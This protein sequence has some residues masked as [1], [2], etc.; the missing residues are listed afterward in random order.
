M[1]NELYHYGVKGMKWGVRRQAKKDAQDYAVAKMY[2]GEGAGT[3]RRLLKAQ[4]D[5]RSKNDPEYKA[6][7]ERQLANQDMSKAVKTAKRQRTAKDV[8]NIV[9]HR[10]SKVAST[11]LHTAV[12]LTPAL[13]AAHQ[14]GID[15]VVYEKGKTLFKDVQ[16]HLADVALQRELHRMGI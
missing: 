4:I 16:G 2:Y 3:R 10:G 8:T 13:I 12:I 5:Q 1:R 15:K 7:F 11:V 6:E 9:Q 14:A